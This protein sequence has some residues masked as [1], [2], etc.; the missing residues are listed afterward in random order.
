MLQEKPA[1]AQEEGPF[2]VASLQEDEANKWRC[3]FRNILKKRRQELKR[4]DIIKIHQPQNKK[5]CVIFVRVHEVEEMTS[6][7]IQ[8]PQLRL[9]KKFIEQFRLKVGSTIDIRLVRDEDLKHITA[10]LV[11]LSFSSQY[12]GRFDMWRFKESVNMQ[13]VQVAELIEYCGVTATVSEIW[14]RDTKSPVDFKSMSAYIDTNTRIVLRSLSVKMC[15]LVQMSSEMQEYHSDGNSFVEVAI[16]FFNQL[17]QEWAK[18][19]ARHLLTIILFTRLWYPSITKKEDIPPA[20]QDNFVQTYDGRFCRDFYRVVCQEVMFREPLHSSILLTLKHDTEQ[21]WELIRPN[22]PDLPPAVVATSLEGNLLEAL[23]LALDSYENH[24]IDRRFDRTGLS[25][26]VVSPGCGIT[27]GHSQV[28]EIV[29]KRVLSEGVG[30]DWV[31]LSS[32]LCPNTPLVLLDLHQHVN[33]VL[34]LE[35]YDQT[36]QY[37]R[38]DRLPEEILQEILTMLEDAA[39]R[40]EMQKPSHLRREIIFSGE[41]P[42]DSWVSYRTPDWV[43][44]C[45]YSRPKKA[46]WEGG[47]HAVCDD[48]TVM[49]RFRRIAQRMAQNAPSTLPP[50]QR[51][52][53]RGID[54]FDFRGAN[55]SFAPIDPHLVAPPVL[56]APEEFDTFDDICWLKPERALWPWHNL[57]DEDIDKE[58]AALAKPIAQK[59]WPQSGDTIAQPASEQS[60]VEEGAQF[61]RPTHSAH[62]VS[63]SQGNASDGHLAPRP[64]TAT[65]P[66]VSPTFTDVPSSTASSRRSNTGWGAIWKNAFKKKPSTSTASAT[67]KPESPA[68]KAPPSSFSSFSSHSQLEVY[69]PSAK[70]PWRPKQQRPQDPEFAKPVY[71]GAH[72]FRFRRLPNEKRPDR[73]YSCPPR[74]GLSHAARNRLLVK[75]VDAMGQVPTVEFQDLSASVSRKWDDDWINTAPLPCR[76]AS[77]PACLKAIETEKEAEYQKL[78]C[79]MPSRASWISKRLHVL[80]LPKDERRDNES[81]LSRQ[82]I[83]DQ[84]S[85]AVTSKPLQRGRGRPFEDPHE[86]ALSMK[87]LQR[88]Q[89]AFAP[90]YGQSETPYGPLWKS[91]IAPACLPLSTGYKPPDLVYGKGHPISKYQYCFRDPQNTTTIQPKEAHSLCIGLLLMQGGQYYES[92]DDDKTK[93]LG[94]QDSRSKQSDALASAS[95]TPTPPPSLATA[96]EQ[97]A[98]ASSSFFSRWFWNKAKKPAAIERKSSSKDLVQRQDSLQRQEADERENAVCISH[99]SGYFEVFCEDSG[100]LI[101]PPRQPGRV[102]EKYYSRDYSFNVIP[103]RR[104]QMHP[105]STTIQLPYSLRAKADNAESP[106]KMLTDLLSQPISITRPPSPSVV[107]A[108]QFWRVR[109]V[110]TPSPASQTNAYNLM[111]RAI[112][113]MNGLIKSCKNFVPVAPGAVGSPPEKLL[114]FQGDEHGLSSFELRVTNFLQV[115]ALPADWP[116][117]KL[118][119]AH[120]LTNFIWLNMTTQQSVREEWA[121]IYYDRYYHPD[122]CFHFEVQWYIATGANIWKMLHSLRSALKYAVEVTKVPIRPLHSTR[123]SNDNPFRVPREIVVAWRPPDTDYVE[124]QAQRNTFFKALLKRTNFLLD[125]HASQVENDSP[126][127]HP[128]YQNTQYIHA[129]GVSVIQVPHDGWKLLY[130]A[131]LLI[132]DS[133]PSFHR[134]SDVRLLAP[135]DTEVLQTLLS[136]CQNATQLKAMYEEAIEPTRQ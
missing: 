8:L 14:T 53:Y 119:N 81:E 120:V 105:I 23:N 89:H 32:P 135:D 38:S 59:L 131:N 71:L 39:S 20:Y 83:T 107:D 22:N 113:N 121:V 101:L 29:E 54:Y 72:T 6:K 123:R 75:P 3:C 117:E 44:Q 13:C 122:R 34:R 63:S 74:M 78:L 70:R 112:G 95:T 79:F 94:P 97:P 87:V 128:A 132:N 92:S 98:S 77:V 51:D 42:A 61:P 58:L 66:S 21:F 24:Y 130:H 48:R 33:D 102:H 9:P 57:S 17:L 111:S 18:S 12:V 88:W 40:V 10:S 133:Q 106:W 62:S 16:S 104:E 56:P 27:T 115:E 2:I 4:N 49:P 64:S 65:T 41:M 68:P 90:A 129:S 30:V 45:I 100:A 26:M 93:V 46:L 31:C 125:M 60:Q 37:L 134:K 86:T 73:R 69:K 114:P 52:D 96:I 50:M 43:H 35:I 136:L 124:M 5:S 15:I 108:C 80:K 47:M 85:G 126:H 82:A 67:S 36:K 19:Q 127:S 7:A 103:Y 91:L 11:E 28:Y 99:P 116:L 110:M 109:Y 84:K 55:T 1:D 118:S 25:L 76:S